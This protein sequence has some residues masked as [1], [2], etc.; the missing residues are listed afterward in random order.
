MPADFVFT[1]EMIVEAKKKKESAKTK[2]GLN[3]YHRSLKKKGDFVLLA[4]DYWLLIAPYLRNE[5]QKRCPERNLDE[6][7]EAFSLF[8]L[9]HIDKFFELSISKKWAAKKLGL[10]KKYTF[11][12]SSPTEVYIEIICKFLGEDI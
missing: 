2:K 1:E 5:L 3:S 6:D 10:P 4:W 12:Q 8:E 11:K 7:L 9:I